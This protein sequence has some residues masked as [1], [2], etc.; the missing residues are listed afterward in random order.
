[1][2]P[3][4]T[5]FICKS[6]AQGKALVPQAT[7]IIVYCGIHGSTCKVTAHGDYQINFA[8]T[9]SCREVVE[10]LVTTPAELDGGAVA[11]E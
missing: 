4:R 11:D 2:F 1:M 5:E 7:A 9:C 10:V 8:E 6:V 3:N